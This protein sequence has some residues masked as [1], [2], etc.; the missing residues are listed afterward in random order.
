MISNRISNFD[1]AMREIYYG[2]QITD[3]QGEFDPQNPS[4]Q[5]SYLTRKAMRHGSLEIFEIKKNSEI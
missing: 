4:I 3:N 2:L 1:A 5:C